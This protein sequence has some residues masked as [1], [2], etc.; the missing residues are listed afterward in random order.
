LQATQRNPDG[1]PFAGR[2]TRIDFRSHLAAKVQIF[3]LKRD[4]HRSAQ[5]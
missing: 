3:P 5:H 2:F 4:I 1:G